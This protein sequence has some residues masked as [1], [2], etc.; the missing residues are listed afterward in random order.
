MCFHSGGW[1]GYDG[2]VDVDYKRHF[3]VH[4][5][6]NEFARGNKHINAIE[7][8]GSFAKLRLTKFIGDSQKTFY[9]HLKECE[10]R[11]NHRD[12]NLYSFL[13]KMFRETPLNLSSP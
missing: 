4:H 8:F 6:A 11:F 2:L 9:S 10:F 7:S 1:K 13:L 5:G 12:Q 3:R